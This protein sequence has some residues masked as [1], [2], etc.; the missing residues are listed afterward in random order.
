MPNG[1]QEYVL[2]DSQWNVVK[3][4]AFDQR[5]G[6]QVTVTRFA[7]MEAAQMA[8]NLISPQAMDACGGVT[9]R[10]LIEA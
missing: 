2:Y 6:K 5:L 7:N 8:I 10:E 9:I 1:K 4:K 3:I